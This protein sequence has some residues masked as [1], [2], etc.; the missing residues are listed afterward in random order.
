MIG[1]SPLVK[2]TPEHSLTPS[3]TRGEV[4]NPEESPYLAMLAP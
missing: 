1:I 3:A 4:Q 2:E